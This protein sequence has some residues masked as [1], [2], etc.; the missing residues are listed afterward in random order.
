MKT[1]FI[2]SHR[3]NLPFDHTMNLYTG[4]RTRL[5]WLMTSKRVLFSLCGVG[6]TAIFIINQ[7]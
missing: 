4:I 1:C 7:I 3:F 6:S 2:L 5:T